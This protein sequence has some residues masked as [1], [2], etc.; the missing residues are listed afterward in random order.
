MTAVV[1][2]ELL[3]FAIADSTAPMAVA[4][5]GTGLS[6][7][8]WRSRATSL[9]WN[10]SSA[11]SCLVVVSPCM[12]RGKIFTYPFFV[13]VLAPA[14]VLVAMAASAPSP[15]DPAGSSVLSPNRPAALRGKTSP[16][17]L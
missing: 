13:S 7:R 11:V 15:P 12:S 4:V 1:C 9:T 3:M 10:T 5:P 2:L 6:V 14:A 16:R 17:P 8:A